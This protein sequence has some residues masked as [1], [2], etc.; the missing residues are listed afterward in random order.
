MA[1]QCCEYPNQGNYKSKRSPKTNEYQIKTEDP[2]KLN[3]KNNTG[4]NADS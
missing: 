3:L 1:V 2:R 4:K